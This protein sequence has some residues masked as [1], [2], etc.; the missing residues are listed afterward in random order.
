MI[1]IS[2]ATP[3]QH[4]IIQSIAHITW[5]V[6]FG[7]LMTPEQLQYMLNMMYS[8]AALAEQTGPK[9]HVF[10]LA[11][12]DGQHLGFASYELH[13]QG[14]K[15]T[16]LHKI[17]ILPSAQGQGV[18]RALFEQVTEIARSAGDQK[19]SLAVKRDNDA[20]KFYEK[21]GYHIVGT[22]DMEIGEGF[23]MRDYVM[24]KSI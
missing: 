1:N 6:T 5:P 16:K 4:P 13:Y 7:D 14:E 21:L 19:I 22:L 9:G 24:E 8:D 23:W 20:V 15:K 2:T 18:G 3:A 11:E 10:L 17:Y 12:K